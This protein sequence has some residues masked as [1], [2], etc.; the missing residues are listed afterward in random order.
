MSPTPILPIQNC[1]VRSRTII[2]H[3]H[4]PLFPFDSH[5]HICAERNVLVEEIEKVVGF[6]FFEIDD[7][8]GLEDGDLAKEEQKRGEKRGKEGKTYELRI[9][10]ESFFTRDG[11]RANNRMDITDGISTNDGTSRESSFGLFVTRM[12]C[13]QAMQ[14][15]LKLG[16]QASICDGHVAKEGIAACDGSVENV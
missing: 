3:D 16:R 10:K 12:D 9:Y 5:L 11:M 8:T 14:T 6:F 7:A 1:R 13:L 15:F 2:P 4:R